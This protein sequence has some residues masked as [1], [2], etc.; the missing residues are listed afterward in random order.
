M[1]GISLFC[2]STLLTYGSITRRGGPV[3]KYKDFCTA[4]A[5]PR[6]LHLHSLR[7]AQSGKD[8]RESRQKSGPTVGGSHFFCEVRQ[9]RHGPPNLVAGG[10]AVRLRTYMLSLYDRRFD[11]LGAGARQ[12]RAGRVFF[13]EG[14]W[15]SWRAFDRSR[16][17]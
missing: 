13:G 5:L 12:W 8:L 17:R 10:E 6:V 3:Y 16:A 11:A 2:N 4:C 14:A 9:N 1:F 7:P 15:N